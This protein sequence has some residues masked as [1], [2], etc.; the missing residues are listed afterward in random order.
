MRKSQNMTNPNIPKHKLKWNQV[1]P[2]P[3][4]AL[5]VR[6]GSWLDS[7]N[8][9]ASLFSVNSKPPETDGWDIRTTVWWHSFSSISGGKV[10]PS[11]LDDRRS[12]LEYKL[13]VE[14][15]TLG[16]LLPIR[17]LE[18]RRSSHFSASWNDG[19]CIAKLYTFDV[20][21]PRAVLKV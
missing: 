2:L 21:W 14:S 5:L 10:D 15:I 19:N 4:C 20:F 16:W 13:V 1:P 8:S 18:G 3:H 11:R 6:L 7:S 9:E 17:T 12:S